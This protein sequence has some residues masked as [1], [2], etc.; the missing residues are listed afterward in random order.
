MP[1]FRVH[2]APLKSIRFAYIKI[3][4]YAPDII[5]LLSFYI[6]MLENAAIGLKMWF[7]GLLGRDGELVFQKLFHGINIFLTLGSFIWGF[8][9]LTPIP[10]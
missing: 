2:L 6:N 8:D 5:K 9:E 3:A 4:R 1:I 10:P 7:M